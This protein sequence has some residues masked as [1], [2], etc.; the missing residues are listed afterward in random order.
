MTQYSLNTS[1]SPTPTPTATK[2]LSPTL[3]PSPQP[4]PASTT[5]VTWSNLAG[6]MGYLYTVTVNCGK[7]V[8]PVET[9]SA[10]HLLSNWWMKFD[11]NP[12]GS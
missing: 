4:S 3:M 9:S 10:F 7:A 12:G 11:T 2:T 6:G 8:T 5:T 1:A